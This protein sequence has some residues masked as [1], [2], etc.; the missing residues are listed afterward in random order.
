MGLLSSD[1][2]TAAMTKETAGV[3]DAANRRIAAGVRSGG[4]WSILLHDG[5][6]G[7]LDRGEAVY[8][9]FE[10]DTRTLLGLSHMSIPD[11]KRVWPQHRESRSLSCTRS[12]TA[13]R[14]ARSLGTC[15]PSGTLNR[16]QNSLVSVSTLASSFVTRCDVDARPR[17]G[18]VST[19]RR[20]S[21]DTA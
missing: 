7:A 6:D 10:I 14:S 18:R 3:G 12:S 2:E 20:S 16:F 11:A 13:M 19:E 4:S 9:Q 5:K 8:D 17:V 21:Y 1:C 15:G